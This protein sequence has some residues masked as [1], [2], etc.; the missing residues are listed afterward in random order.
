MQ[1]TEDKGFLTM[2][3]DHCKRA[4]QLHETLETLKKLQKLVCEGKGWR[5][6]INATDDDG[7]IKHDTV[8]PGGFYGV[9]FEPLRSAIEIQMRQLGV[10]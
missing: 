6:Q 9:L 4:V 8:I 5:L 10:D 2:E 7:T 3:I 1:K